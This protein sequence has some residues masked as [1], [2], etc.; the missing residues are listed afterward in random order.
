MCISKMSLR[1]AQMNLNAG[2]IL[3]L[4]LISTLRTKI[5]LKGALS[6]IGSMVLRPYNLSNTY[7]NLQREHLMVFR[8]PFGEFISFQYSF[9]M[10]SMMSK[11]AWKMLKSL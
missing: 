10:F 3:I 6:I 4:L 8:D 2:K 11:I 9:I 7:F 1:H 5:S